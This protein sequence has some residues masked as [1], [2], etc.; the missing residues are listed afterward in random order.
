MKSIV[1][2]LPPEIARQV[3]PD[4]RKNE[5]QYWAVRD[6]LLDKYR[7]QWIGFAD[8]RVV[9]SG[10]SPV[11]VFHAAEATGLHPFF[12]RV[13]KEEQPCRIRRASFACDTAHAGESFGNPAP[14]AGRRSRRQ[15]LTC[16]SAETQVRL[17]RLGLS[18]NLSGK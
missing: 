10:T 3:H 4:C 8:G 17:S 7:G 6:Q 9:A 2:Q 15:S 18:P 13:G 11:A 12:I 1:N 16:L 14:R 5:A